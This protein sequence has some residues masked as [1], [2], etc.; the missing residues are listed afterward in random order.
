LLLVER[1]IESFGTSRSVFAFLEAVSWA[2]VFLRFCAILLES[3]ICYLDCR[4]EGM[5]SGSS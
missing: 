5:V 3:A 4:A 1:L 2:A